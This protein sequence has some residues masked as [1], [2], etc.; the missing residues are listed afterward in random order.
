MLATRAQRLIASVESPEEFQ[1]ASGLEAFL[2][3]VGLPSKMPAHSKAE[4][5]TVFACWREGFRDLQPGWLVAHHVDQICRLEALA[6][7][8]VRALFERF[9]IINFGRYDPHLL[10]QQLDDRSLVAT[11]KEPLHLFYSRS[12]HSGA[13]SASA[14]IHNLAVDSGHPP[15]IH[16][17]SSA[18]S[19]A[20][21]ALRANHRF[22]GVK[23]VG[24][25]GHGGESGMIDAPEDFTRE[26]LWSLELDTLL[27]HVAGDPLHVMFA[28][29]HSG[30]HNGMVDSL[31][32]RLK[33]R[34]FTL[35][36]GNGAHSA[37]GILYGSSQG[38]TI[39][40]NPGPVTRY[41]GT[42][43][44]KLTR[45]VISSPP[46]RRDRRSAGRG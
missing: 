43:D 25:M 42:A 19:L 18:K 23:A 40:V 39:Q 1:A 46:S 21:L 17:F 36:G 3:R 35:V 33:G 5:S 6:P 32:L 22:G 9:N 44:G 15:V 4:P 34:N 24:I 28:S 7:G 11:G 12:D 41:V 26:H 14:L 45:D 38:F 2:G 27:R 30:N 16:E 29:C 10:L 13:F 8:S 20:R 31:A 37:S